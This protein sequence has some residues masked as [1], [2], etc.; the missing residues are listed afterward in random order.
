MKEVLLWIWQLPQNLVGYFLTRSTKEIRDFRCSD[1][2]WVSVYYTSNVFGCGVS[3]GKYIIL[4]YDKY[5]TFTSTLV[6]NHE[7]GH[8]KQSRYL[9]WCY[10]IVVGLVSALFNNVWDRLFHKKWTAKK[11][12]TW[13][14]SRFPENWADA[15]GNVKRSK[16]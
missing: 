15:L 4:D 3:L 6:V 10:L 16:V 13:Y 2:E 7:H 14:Y 11:R 1:G 9:G 12:N 8:Q 5:Y